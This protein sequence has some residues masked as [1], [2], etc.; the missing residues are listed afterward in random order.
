M[1]WAIDLEAADYGDELGIPIPIK[2]TTIA[3]TGTI[4][5]LS[6]SSEGIHP[7]FAKY[8]VQ[9]VRFLATMRTINE[10][11]RRVVM[12]KTASIRRTQRLFQY[13][14]AMSSSITMTK[15]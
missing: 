1:R 9:R 5:K 15:N 10:K 7:I 3:P 11:S 2:T 14:L 8:F 6:G 13:L 4:A 12:S